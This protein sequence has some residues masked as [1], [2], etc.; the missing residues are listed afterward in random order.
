MLLI[1]KRN[2]CFG[3]N[4]TLMSLPVHLGHVWWMRGIFPHVPN[5][6]CPGSGEKYHSFIQPTLTRIIN[7]FTFTK[8]YQFPLFSLE[9]CAT[10][11][12]WSR[13]S[14]SRTPPSRSTPTLT[15]ST[16]GCSTTRAA[17]RSSPRRRWRRG[18]WWRSSWS[19]SP[20]RQPTQS[21]VG[22]KRREA[23][24]YKKKSAWKTAWDSTLFPIR[25]WIDI[26]WLNIPE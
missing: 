1:L 24:Q 10:R 19:S 15:S 4:T 6:A 17:R 11:G 20:P 18:R 23:F 13:T 25:S 12:R 14:N 5:R 2:F 21:T 22:S 7:H 9:R 26:F 3:V 8:K 16:S